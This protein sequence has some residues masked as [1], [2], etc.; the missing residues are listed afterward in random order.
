MTEASPMQRAACRS[1]GTKQCAFI[2]LSSLPTRE[3]GMCPE[4]AKVWTDAAIEMERRRRPDGPLCGMII[5]T[6]RPA[7]EVT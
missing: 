3:P 5:G 2:C 7:D 6:R 1:M 4:A